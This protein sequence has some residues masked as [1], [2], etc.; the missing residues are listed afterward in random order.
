MPPADEGV[1]ANAGLREKSGSGRAILLFARSPEAEAAAK[2]LDGAERLFEAIA[3]AW[4]GVARQCGAAVIVACSPE[5]RA[6]F[7]RLTGIDAFVDQSGSLFGERL[8][9]AARAAF[10]LHFDHLLITGIDAPPPD[11]VAVNAALSA[12]EK[13]RAAAVVAPSTDGGINFLAV[14][15]ADVSLLEAFTPR[16]PTL[17]A[18]CRMHFRGRVLIETAALPDLDSTDVVRVA[19]RQSLWR[20]YRRFFRRAAPVRQIEAPPVRTSGTVFTPAGLRAPPFVA[21]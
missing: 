14:T 9:G 13:R 19:L 4:I 21:I 12:I 3:G 20:P 17:I 6:S 7:R 1:A 5:H 10:S 2:R 8:A 18:R 15:S 11:A 16:D